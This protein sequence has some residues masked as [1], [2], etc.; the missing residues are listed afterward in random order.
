MST[1]SIAVLRRGIHG[2]SIDRYAEALRDRLDGAG[3][4][5]ATT[6]AEE[7]ELVAEAEIVTG[8]GIDEELLDAAGELR[9]FAGILA[10]TDHL[11][12]D[13][14]ADRGVAVTNAAGVHGPNVAEHVIGS[15]LAFAAGLHIGWRRQRRHEWRHYQ[16]TE[17]ADSVVTIVGLGAI[18]TAIVDRLEGFGVRTIGVRYTPENGGPTDEVIGFD[19]PAVHRALARTD[20]LVLACPL[21]ETTRGLVDDEALATLPPEAVVVN[22]ARGPVVETDALVGAIQREDIRGAALD[23]TDP[24][25]LPADHPLWRFENVL[26]TAHS[27]GHT[28]RYYDRVADILADN[29]RRIEET[30]AYADLRNQVV[31]PAASPDR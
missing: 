22:I 3:V 28:P 26:I 4:D 27:A 1:P 14:L 20:Y 29:V 13:A 11:P 2:L 30:G 8:Y 10:G 24:E 19:P 23:V 6:P 21:T 18:G 9:L 12:L 17:L 25:P 7:R 16:A 5:R 31:P 15:M